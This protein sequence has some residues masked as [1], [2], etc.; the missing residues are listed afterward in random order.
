VLVLKTLFKPF[1]YTQT[2]Y[3]ISILKPEAIIDVGIKKRAINSEKIFNFFY[4][5]PDEIWIMYEGR[6]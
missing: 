3:N 4:S 1:D 2:C 5:L 6:F